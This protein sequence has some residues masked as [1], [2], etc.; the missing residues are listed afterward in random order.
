MRPINMNLQMQAMM[1]KYQR[2]RACRRTPITDE[3]GGIF[4]RGVLTIAQARLQGPSDNGVLFYLAVA[5]LGKGN[6][7]IQEFAAKGDNLGSTDGVVL[8]RALCPVLLGDGIR[9]IEG[10][11]EAEIGRA[12]CRERVKVYAGVG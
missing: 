6:A 12:S 11:V 1:D 3:L 7:V 9:A 4:E 8:G 5:P 10:I 2:L